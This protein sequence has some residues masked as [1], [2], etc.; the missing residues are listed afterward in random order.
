MSIKAFAIHTILHTKLTGEDVSA[1]K[2]FDADEDEFTFLED[3][4][5][6]R[7]A[8]DEEIAIANGANPQ[9]RVVAE[10]VVE[11]TAAAEAAAAEAD[12]KIPESGEPNDPNSA[13]KGATRKSKK[14]AAAE[15]DEDE[16]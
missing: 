7:L 15:A 9:K 8:T 6:V 2:V 1:G 16:I 12:S 5:A 14:T 13:P 3:R 4:G 10:P 11:T